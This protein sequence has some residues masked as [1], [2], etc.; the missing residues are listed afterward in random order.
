[1]PE[2]D[3]FYFHPDHLGSTSYISTRNGSI[4]Q[5][6]EYIAF[7]EILFE[8][9]SSSFSSPYLFN[10]KELDRET[11]LSYYGARYL[12]MKT[13][14]WLNVDPL[15]EKFIDQSPYSYCFNN[16]INLIDPTGMGPEDP[17]PGFWKGFFGSI[18]RGIVGVAKHIINNPNHAGYGYS[19][20][21]KSPN[22]N[23]FKNYEIAWNDQLNPTWQIQN[24]SSN[25]VY[26]ATGFIGGIMDGDGARVAQSIPKLATVYATIS[27]LRG[28]KLSAGKNNFSLTISEGSYSSSEM[29]AANYMWKEGNN[30]TLRPP[31]GTRTATGT[32]GTSDLVVNG[33]NY[34]VYTPISNNPNSIISAIAKK[35]KQANGIVLDLSKTNVTADQLGNVLK[36]VQGAG[37]KN[38]KD[39]KIMPKN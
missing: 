20:T 32:G 22:P 31:S 6:V 36:R 39:V 26:G 8:E 29:N 16:P 7:G 28:F 3:I 25:L 5:H 11:N 27:I 21:M 23:D 17:V 38:I 9:H 12:D 14:L 15:A 35:N 13:S 34:D 24:F 30:V 19:H 33:V 1:M 4:S 10:G 18:G 37:A 2:N